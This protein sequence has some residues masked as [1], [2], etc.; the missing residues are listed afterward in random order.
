MGLPTKQLVP[1]NGQPTIGPDRGCGKEVFVHR[2][3]NRAA[4]CYDSPCTARRLGR[5]RFFL[6]QRS[7]DARWMLLL[8]LLTGVLIAS[9]CQWPSW[10][11]GRQ[12]ESAEEILEK[13]AEKERKMREQQQK[14]LAVFPLRILPH[15][16]SEPQLFVKPG[17][18]VAGQQAF[19]ANREDLAL[20][21]TTWAGMSMDE[22]IDWPGTMYYVTWQRALALP[23]QQE[24]L[25]DLV[26]FLPSP[27]PRWLGPQSNVRHP[28]LVTEIHVKSAPKLDTRD[29]QPVLLMPSYQYHFVVLA[30]V[31][32]SY[33]FIKRLLCV[34]EPPLTLITSTPRT[35]YRV[36]IPNKLE[37]FVPLPPEWFSWTSV[38]YL[39]WDGI[40]P[41]L[42][43]P[44]QQQALLDW[45]HFGGQLI[46]SGPGSA[47]K[48]VGSFLEPYLPAARVSAVSLSQADFDELNA[49]WT[50]PDKSV[51]GRSL[52]RLSGESLAGIQLEPAPHGQFVPGTGRLVCEARLGQGRIVMTA[53]PLTDRDLLRWPS[54]DSF[55]NG[56]LMRRPSRQFRIDD[57]TFLISMN[58]T[59]DAV[60]DPRLA[61]RLRYFSRDTVAED[62]DPRRTPD[63]T[64]PT[65]DWL[66]S[67]DGTSADL[68]LRQWQCKGFDARRN[69]AAIWNR[70]VADVECGV[71]GWSDF[72]G[73]ARAARVALRRA[74][75]IKVPNRPFVLQVLAVYILV[76]VPVNWGLFRLLGRVEWA[77]FTAPIL[78][79]VGAIAVARLAQLDIGF[80]RSGTE[81]AF[82]EVHAGYSRAHL[83]RYL[84][85]YTSLTTRYRLRSENS[86]FLAFPFAD[87]P[88]FERRPHDPQ[89]PFLTRRERFVSVEDFTVP[90]NSTGLLHTEQMTDLGG[91]FELLVD[92]ADSEAIQLA[93]RS[94]LTVRDAI[95]YCCNESGVTMYASV[96]ELP[97]NSQRRVI[98]AWLP[99]DQWPPDP[100]QNHSVLGPVPVG[101]PD[102]SSIRLP[103][104]AR[105]AAQQV[106]LAPG[107]WRLIGWTDRVWEDLQIEPTPNQWRTGTC[108]LVHLRAGD[109]PKPEPDKNLVAD[110]RR[111]DSA[112]DE[113][114]PQP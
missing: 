46:I 28:S 40:S 20:E 74:S 32:E 99:G 27:S 3:F 59:V 62:R 53:F 80:V 22:P 79:V 4:A 47:E 61:T 50:V 110:V 7:G 54:Y 12:P 1:N 90:S 52:L 23:K 34:T 38:A 6:W 5:L 75:G 113:T 100:W 98:P 19:I 68:W 87:D 107:E 49:H 92:P 33:G 93:N 36:Q 77:W 108:V 84:A 85:L 43:T 63:N 16:Q 30:R 58:N 14:P 29:T 105:V 91:S 112:H 35:F 41:D 55:W 109:L 48:L 11:Q 69:Q 81:V 86:S 89:P 45:L 97:E 95:V 78:A 2:D 13:Q 18:V 106:P 15:D 9:G 60:E 82:L 73:V 67:P 96:G 42:L 51:D 94:Q 25:A 72:S 76:L 71:G 37:Q 10:F 83:A 21:I 88:P 17:H 65:V 102:D 26:F 103:E 8:L 66:G 104:L 111:W 101:T 31:P 114:Q 44:D 24:K 57:S 56:A 39:V 70:E 64:A